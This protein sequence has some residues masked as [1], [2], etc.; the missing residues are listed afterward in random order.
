MTG[1][2]RRSTSSRRSRMSWASPSPGMSTECPFVTLLLPGRSVLV[3]KARKPG[4][5]RSGCGRAR[6]AHDGAPERIALRR[7][8]GFDVPHGPLRRARLPA[9]LRRSGRSLPNVSAINFDDDLRFG[10]VRLASGVVPALISGAIRNDPAPEGTPLAIAV[11]GRIRGMTRSFDLNGG[12][13][14]T[15]MVPESAFRDGPNAVEVYS[16]ARSNGTFRLTALGGTGA[17]DGRVVAASTNSGT[18]TAQP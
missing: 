18:V 7:G 10:D 6:R 9:D 2:R 17:T 11:N 15:A 4:Q 14:F 12:R 5:W 8:E 16:V 13:R 1:T 3:S